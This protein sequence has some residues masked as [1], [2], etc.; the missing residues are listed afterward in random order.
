MKGIW[1]GE[2][3]P[4]MLLHG[5]EYEIIGID[6]GLDCYGVID[7]TEDSFCYPMELFEITEKFPIPPTRES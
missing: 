6:E 5:K 4:F 7:E 1:L 3:D 2:S